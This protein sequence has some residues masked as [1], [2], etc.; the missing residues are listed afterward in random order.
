MDG[1]SFVQ[2]FRLKVSGDADGLGAG[3][4]ARWDAAA[5]GCGRG[6]VAQGCTVYSSR[7][8]EMIRNSISGA[9]DPQ[10]VLFKDRSG[11]G[12][13]KSDVTSIIT[14]IALHP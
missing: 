9:A 10:L 5:E 13:A 12:R 11:Q 3:Y 2:G 7:T 8:F 1:K 4:V 14:N 6:S